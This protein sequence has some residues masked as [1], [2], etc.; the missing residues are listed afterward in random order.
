MHE[1]S[2]PRW[3]VGALSWA[4]ALGL[5]ACTPTTAAPPSQSTP[6]PPAAEDP[7]ISPVDST[8]RCP[9]IPATAERFARGIDGAHRA[10][11]RDDQCHTV[12]LDCS[13]ISCSAVHLDHAAAYATPIDC[14]GYTGMMANYDCL[15]RFS[16][17]APRCRDGCCTSERIEPLQ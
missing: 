6:P 12:K 7:P 15:P 4:T 14:E 1:P 8:A 5:L 11:E 13:N 9:S 10:C 2:N 17:E 3:Y 16:I